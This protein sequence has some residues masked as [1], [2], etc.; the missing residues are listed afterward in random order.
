MRRV[1]QCPSCWATA[2][3]CAHRTAPPVAGEPLFRQG[4]QS[5]TTEPQSNE[6]IRRPPELVSTFVYRGSSHRR[7]SAACPKFDMVWLYR[8]PI[9]VGKRG[10]TFSFKWFLPALAAR[11]GGGGRHPVAR[12]PILFV[13]NACNNFKNKPFGLYAKLR[14]LRHIPVCKFFGQEPVP[15]W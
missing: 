6:L 10:V 13:Y 14:V 8:L 3:P 11:G 15:Y 12:A 1:P 2:A 4:C 5:D 7:K 9:P